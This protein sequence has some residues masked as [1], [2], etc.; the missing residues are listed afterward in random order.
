MPQSYHVL[1]WGLFI[2]AAVLLSACSA[3]KREDRVLFEGEFFKAKAGHIDRDNRSEFNVVVGDISRSFEGAREAARYEAT[4]YC[5]EEFGTSDIIWISG[6]DD[7]PD[8]LQIVNDR[9]TLHG[10]CYF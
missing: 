8:T 4:K 3:V 5:I 2:G 10:T 1:A 9:L 6:P 7:D